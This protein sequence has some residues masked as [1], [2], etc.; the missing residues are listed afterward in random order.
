MQ[1]RLIS[2]LLQPLEDILRLQLIPT[3]T[4]RPPPNNSERDLLALPG[5][6]LAHIK[7]EQLGAKATNYRLKRHQLQQSASDLLSTLSPSLQR[8]LTLAQEK[9]A[10]S[11]FTALPINE[12]G[13]A[14]HKEAFRDAL[15]LQ[16]GW[17]P[18]HAPT[19][20]ACGNSFNMEHILSCPKGGF[21]SIRHNEIIRDITATLLSEVCHDVATEPHLQTLSGEAF[22]HATANIQDGAR[23][24]IVT[25]GFWVG[26]FEK[27][28]YDVRVFNPFAPSNQHSQSEF[29]YRH[30]ENLK[31]RLY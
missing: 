16:Y 28:Y 2:H 10:S 19:T 13:F 23:L 17:L 18:L 31:R 6:L 25:S 5:R 21:P 14:L 29:V 4:G 30:H 20:C 7:E 24:D 11:W 9:G 12:F 27:T 26:R 22:P 8:A 15:A 1:Y 3:L